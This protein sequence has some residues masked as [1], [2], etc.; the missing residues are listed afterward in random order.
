MMTTIESYMRMGQNKLRK[1]AIGT[2]IHRGGK[3]AGCFLG[4]FLYSGTGLA[5]VALPVAMGW[6]TALSGLGAVLAADRKSVV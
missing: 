3:L 5:G 6:V 2:E 4:G 1:W